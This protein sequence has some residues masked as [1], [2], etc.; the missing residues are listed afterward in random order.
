MGYVSGSSTHPTTSTDQPALDR[1]ALALALHQDP[2]AITAHPDVSF[3]I[4]LS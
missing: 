3:L 4:S 2:R 1:L